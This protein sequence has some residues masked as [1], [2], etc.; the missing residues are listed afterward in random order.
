ML[1][2]K[3]E[4]LKFAGR[5]GSLPGSGRSTGNKASG[6][7]A[8]KWATSP[9]EALDPNFIIIRRT[10]KKQKS[11]ACPASMGWESWLGPE[12]LPS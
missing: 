10:Q 2:L 11:Q 4:K 3:K 5:S 8:R 1:A 9:I 7:L 6:T 12:N